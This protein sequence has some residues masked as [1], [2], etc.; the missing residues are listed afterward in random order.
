MMIAPAKTIVFLH[1]PKTAGTTLYHLIQRRYEPGQFYIIA[2]IIQDLA[3]FQNMPPEGK[4]PIRLLA[5]HVNFGIH[6]YLPQPATYFTFLRQPVDLVISY[7]YYMR[8]EVSHPNFHMA[9]SMGMPQ[10]LE[11]RLDENMSN[12]QTRMLAGKANSGDYYECTAADLEIAK[13]NLRHF[14]VV[15][16]AER[17]DESLLLLQQAFGWQNLYYARMNVTRKKPAQSALP[18]DVIQAITQANQLDEALYHFAADLFAGQIAQQGPHFA[19]QV[20]AFQ[21]KNRWLYPFRYSVWQSRR[22]RWLLPKT[23]SLWLHDFY[24]RARNRLLS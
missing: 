5:G 24:A 6:H 21:R 20:R 23:A 10:F 2:D 22:L 16:L 9:K 4:T 1:I 12:M 18:S 19:R 14:A 15:G 8:A 17:F 13:E 11:S 3:H 7:F